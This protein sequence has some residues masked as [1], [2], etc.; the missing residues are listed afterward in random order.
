MVA[1]VLAVM[2]IALEGYKTQ[3]GLTVYQQSWQEVLPLHLC[4]ISS[5][6]CCLMLLLRSYRLFE[7]TYF[8]GIG[9]SVA[10]MLTPD[11]EAAFPH[12][13]FLGFFVGHALVACSVLFAMT[14]YDFRPRL[15][16]I[17]FAAVVSI[18]YMG[19]VA[20]INLALD[21]NYLYLSHKPASITVYQYLGPWPWYLL[22]VWVIGVAVS[23]V[24]Y[25]PFAWRRT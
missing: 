4:R 19:V 5:Y 8:W 1:I 9:G 18:V 3:Q 22:S 7:V 6:L 20:L 14:A 21:T 17:G 11:L 23:F 10:A 12:P 13:L 2:L 24:L 16:S 25:A 15:R